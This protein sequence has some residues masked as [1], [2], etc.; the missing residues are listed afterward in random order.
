MVGGKGPSGALDTVY[1][2]SV[3]DDTWTLMPERLDT[4]RSGMAAFTV[5][6]G[7]FTR[8]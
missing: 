5:K 3:E 6:K 2:Y 4:P 8:C 1:M 7:S